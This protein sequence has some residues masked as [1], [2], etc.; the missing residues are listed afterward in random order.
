MPKPLSATHHAVST[1][2][3]TTLRPDATTA[4]VSFTIYG[5]CY[6]LKNSHIW[7][8]GRS[9]KHPKAKQFEADFVAQ[10]PHSAKL[11]LG[12]RNRLLRASV[13]VYYPTWLQ[14]VD[15][16]IVWDLLQKTGVVSNDRWIRQ[17]FIDGLHVDPDRPRVEVVVEEI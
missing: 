16:E 7:G 3:G 17:K 13:T 8:R 4:S 15:V 12:S 5:Q 2:S 6:S 14:D 11:G 9:V 10:V 1:A